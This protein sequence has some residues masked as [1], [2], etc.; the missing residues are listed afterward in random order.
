MINGYIWVCSLFSQT[1]NWFG[2]YLFNR[3]QFCIVEKCKSESMK[4]TCVEPQ[5]SILGP[6]LFLIYFNDFE[7]CLKNAKSL[8]FADDTVI[9]IEGKKHI[10]SYFQSNQLV[11]NLKKGKTEAMLFGTFK[12]LSSCSSKLSL[13]YDNKTIET[14][15]T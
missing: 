14:T 13:S 3:E 10:S 11:I 8:S 12:C 15:E 2:E 1:K 9:Y 6:L 4:I 7:K 5:G